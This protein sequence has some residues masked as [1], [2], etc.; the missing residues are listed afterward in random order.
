[1]TL[2]R[3]TYGCSVWNRRPDTSLKSKGIEELGLLVLQSH[4]RCYV[5][6]WGRLFENASLIPKAIFICL[7]P[8][9]KQSEE[10]SSAI[11]T[12]VSSNCPYSLTIP[13][14]QLDP[15]HTHSPSSEHASP[16][17]QRLYCRRATYC[18]YSAIYPSY[19]FAGSS[20]PAGN[21]PFHRS[22]GATPAGL[23]CLAVSANRSLSDGTAQCS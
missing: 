22:S 1:M 11:P 18:S 16:Y 4:Y 23:I 10:A 9:S 13:R 17:H 20:K 7:S 14:D 5:H 6:V 15:T 19:A 21:S 3:A 8:R 2:K 12:T